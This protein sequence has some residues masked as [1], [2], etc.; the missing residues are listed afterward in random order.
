MWFKSSKTK[1]REDF[2]KALQAYADDL[3][4]GNTKARHTWNYIA[5]EIAKGTDDGTVFYGVFKNTL[6]LPPPKP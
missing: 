3:P 2:A 4:P 6:K 5:D 1:A